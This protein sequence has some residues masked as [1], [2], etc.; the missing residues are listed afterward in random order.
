VRSHCKLPPES[1]PGA[2]GAALR[3]VGQG[4]GQIRPPPL[5]TPDDALLLRLPSNVARN[6]LSVLGLRSRQEACLNKNKE[7][8]HVWH[9]LHSGYSQ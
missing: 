2:G 4:D 1:T 9:S 5:T 3:L 7:S 8:L 6:T